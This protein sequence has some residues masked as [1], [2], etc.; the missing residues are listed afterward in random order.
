MKQ[1]KPR[2]DPLW[3]DKEK[4]LRSAVCFI[5]DV[6][7]PDFDLVEALSADPTAFDCVWKLRTSTKSSEYIG[8][9]DSLNALIKR[10]CS[11]RNTFGEIDIIESD[12]LFD[13][14]HIYRASNGIEVHVHSSYKP[15]ILGKT[16]PVLSVS[17]KG[18]AYPVISYISEG[19]IETIN[20]ILRTHQEECMTPQ[21]L[22]TIINRVIIPRFSGKERQEIL[23]WLYTNPSELFKRRPYAMTKEERYEWDHGIVLKINRPEIRRETGNTKKNTFDFVRVEMSIRS[24]YL[25]VEKLRAHK[26]ELIQK[27]LDKIDSYKPYQKY[28]VPVKY[29]RLYRMTLL[30]CGYVVLDFELPKA[31]DVLDNFN[32]ETTRDE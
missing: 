11:A 17:F 10:V 15:L 16:L 27:A 2:I 3:W 9:Q 13:Y 8:P 1:K 12:I 21:D 26:K 31:T 30:R 20:Y 19:F 6:L 18:V 22:K 5:D 24:T 25:S 4:G 7:V 29:L 23:E 32:W 28:G 14:Y